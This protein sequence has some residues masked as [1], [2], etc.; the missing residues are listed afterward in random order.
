[1]IKL[2]RKPAIPRNPPM[3]FLRMFQ[4]LSLQ[5]GNWCWIYPII[6]STSPSTLCRSAELSFGGAGAIDSSV[7]DADGLAV[8]EGVAFAGRGG[9]VPRS[10]LTRPELADFPRVPLVPPRVRL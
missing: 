7:G 6:F 10:K 3:L 2:R 5:V 9:G 8:G 1:M 4:T